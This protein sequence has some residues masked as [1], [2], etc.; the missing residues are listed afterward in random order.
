MYLC[1]GRKP[2]ANEISLP[3][4]WLNRRSNSLTHLDLKR[5]GL[6]SHK[7]MKKCPL[8]IQD[9]CFER[10]PRTAF[11]GSVNPAFTLTG[12]MRQI[13]VSEFIQV[14]HHVSFV[15]DTLH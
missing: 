13:K 10:N 2:V 4:K 11:A 9:A 1:H 14:R 3:L 7:T 8:D 6:K 5:S 12:L 15:I